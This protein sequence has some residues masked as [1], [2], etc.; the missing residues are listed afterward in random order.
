MRR[1][2]RENKRESNNLFDNN[3][4]IESTYIP[5]VLAWSSPRHLCKPSFQAQTRS[6]IIT[7]SPCRV[8]AGIMQWPGLVLP[9]FLPSRKFIGRRSMVPPITRCARASRC[10]ERVKTILKHSLFLTYERFFISPRPITFFFFF[11]FYPRSNASLEYIIVE[12]QEIL[13]STIRW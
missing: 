6:S 8:A 9:P 4:W 2:Y 5:G 1:I 7:K 10:P 12:H 3:Y 11:L 13:A